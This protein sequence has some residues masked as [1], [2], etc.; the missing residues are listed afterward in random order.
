[1]EA[2]PKAKINRKKGN[3]WC[4][5]TGCAGLGCVFN[6]V[7]TDSCVAETDLNSSN[8]NGNPDANKAVFTCVP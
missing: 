6:P 3:M 4:L 5:T 1:M 8:W 7:G 2:N